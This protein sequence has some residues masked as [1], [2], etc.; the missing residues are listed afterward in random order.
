MNEFDN[1][2]GIFGL[3][4]MPGESDDELRRRLRV[5]LKLGADKFNLPFQRMCYLLA[6]L[7]VHSAKQFLPI[8]INIYGSSIYDA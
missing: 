2:G 1:I 4:R 5:M 8:G 6:K 3:Q 7:Q